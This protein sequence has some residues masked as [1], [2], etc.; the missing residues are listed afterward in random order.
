[1]KILFLGAEVAPYVSVGG[2]SQV[3]YFLPRAL[4]ARGDDVRIFTARYGAMKTGKDQ[5]NPWHIRQII[6]NLQVPIEHTYR[7]GKGTAILEQMLAEQDGGRKRRSNRARVWRLCRERGDRERRI[8]GRN[9]Q[10]RYLGL[11]AIKTRCDDLFSR[12]RGILRIAQE[13]LRIRR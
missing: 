12:Q 1:M 4:I 13:C 10:M 5:K 8:R 7:R 6:R 3:M 9:D 2:L 11:H